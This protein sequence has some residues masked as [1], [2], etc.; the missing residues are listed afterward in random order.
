MLAVSRSLMFASLTFVAVVS[1]G[2]RDF[3][4]KDVTNDPA[5]GNFAP[6]VGAWKVESPL[7][8]KHFDDAIGPDT[9][10]DTASAL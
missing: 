4:K 6:V 8:L 3:G 1:A 10:L 7:T 5:H 2:C 9:G